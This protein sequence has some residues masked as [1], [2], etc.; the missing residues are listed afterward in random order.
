MS[1]AA[2]CRWT[3]TWAVVPLAGPVRSPAW[4]EGDLTVTHTLMPP[5]HNALHY[6]QCNTSHGTSSGLEA[7][8]PPDPK[9]VGGPARAGPLLGVRDR[10]CTSR[11][12]AVCPCA[13][14]RSPAMHAFPAVNGLDP[15]EYVSGELGRAGANY[16]PVAAASQT[17]PGSTSAKLKPP[18]PELLLALAGS[19]A[20]P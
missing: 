4:A 6:I 19:G 17:C 7:P 14:L 2:Q 13:V 18:K 9:K 12:A 16:R 1:A 5:R 20:W 10:A 15:N 3:P 11:H 8:R